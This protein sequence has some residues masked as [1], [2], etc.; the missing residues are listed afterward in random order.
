MYKQRVNVA[1]IL[2]M[3]FVTATA[4]AAW[5]GIVGYENARTVQPSKKQ[6]TQQVETILQGVNL[7]MLGMN[8]NNTLAAKW[9][10]DGEL[11]VVRNWA[12]GFWD[13]NHG[14]SIDLIKADWSG[15][16]PVIA[17]LGY[18]YQNK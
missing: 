6:D 10:S 17:S 2:S 15:K 12:Y 18:A 5:L 16:G 4:Q 1:L 7:D 11:S 13:A 14:M 8:W 3:M 9:K